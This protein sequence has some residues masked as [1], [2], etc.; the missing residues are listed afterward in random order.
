MAKN[1][2]RHSTFPRAPSPERPVEH[3]C[4]QLAWTPS[5]SLAWRTTR[6]ASEIR[7]GT[8]INPLRRRAVKQLRTF[9]AEIV[10]FV[11]SYSPAWVASGAPF[12]FEGIN[13]L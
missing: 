8:R 10:E 9:W 11:A 5:S 12:R 6:G 4:S 7:L 2:F 1:D 13:P 3:R